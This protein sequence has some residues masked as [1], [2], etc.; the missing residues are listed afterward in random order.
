[1]KQVFAKIAKIGE[2]VRAAELMKVELFDAKEALADRDKAGN[3]TYAA[4]QMIQKAKASVQ[5]SIFACDAYISKYVKELDKWP[6]NSTTAVAYRKA[7]DA[8]KSQ[9]KADMDFLAML[10]KIPTF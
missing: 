1:M 9:K 7:I 2:E 10:K 4:Y 3:G 6:T 5:K 8:M